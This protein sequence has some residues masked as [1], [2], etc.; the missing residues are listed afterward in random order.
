MKKE[1]LI[2]IAKNFKIDGEPIKIEKC[3]SGHINKTYAVT[4]KTK[5][6]ENKKYILQYVNTNVFP[7]LPELMNNIKKVTNYMVNK[8]QDESLSAYLNEKVFAGQ[9][10]STINPD[11]GDVAGFDAYM[12]KYVKALPVMAAAVSTVDAQ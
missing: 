6:G 1:E 5:N 8:A 10:G 9:E 4:Y 7:N 3:E 12:E 11:A 2:E